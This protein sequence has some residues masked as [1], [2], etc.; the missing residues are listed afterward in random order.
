MAMQ[1][2]EKILGG[3]VGAARVAG[4]GALEPGAALI[5]LGLFLLPG[6][7]PGQRLTRAAD[8]DPTTAGVVFFCFHEGGPD[9]AAPP[10]SQGSNENHLRQ[11]YGQ[12]GRLETLDDERR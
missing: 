5:T 12:G 4:G 6:G 2:K 8:D 3:A 11:P 1:K 10:E 9:L 7:R